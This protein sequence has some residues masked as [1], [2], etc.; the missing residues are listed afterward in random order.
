MEY[1]R[2]ERICN[3]YSRI[4]VEAGGNGEWIMNAW[5]VGPNETPSSESIDT[6]MN[7]PV[8]D[9]EVRLG[10]ICPLSHPGE[11]PWFYYIFIIPNSK[12]VIIFIYSFVLINYLQKSIFVHMQQANLFMI[13]S[14]RVL[15][16]HI[17]TTIV[18]LI[19]PIHFHYHGVKM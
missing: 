9:P 17:K 16:K 15:T 2:E 3:F 14:E 19:S 7:C 12:V 10:G 6:L 1:R 8:W 13:M 18:Q 4:D 11:N 5:S